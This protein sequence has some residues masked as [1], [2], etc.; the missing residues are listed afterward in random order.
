MIVAVLLGGC[1]LA[2]PHRCQR[3]PEWILVWRSVD[4]SVSDRHEAA[5]VLLSASMTVSDVT[6]ILGQ[7][8]ASYRERGLSVG[9]EARPFS[10]KGVSYEFSDGSVA[11]LFAPN[12]TPSQE[13]RADQVILRNSEGECLSRWSLRAGEVLR[14]EKGVRSKNSSVLMSGD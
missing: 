8:S 13:W 11:I 12:A 1:R 7:Y 6:R 4:A 10:R 3:E 9:V 14:R 2:A 5:R